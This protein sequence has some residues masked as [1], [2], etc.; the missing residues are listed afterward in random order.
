MGE[1][2]HVACAACRH[3]DGLRCGAWGT[4][5][6]NPE[7]TVCARFAGPDEEEGEAHVR[8][9]GLA[10]LSP[11]WLHRLEP[12]GQS[13]PWVQVAR[14]RR[15]R[16]TGTQALTRPLSSA[17]AASR[18]TNVL[19][20]GTG[21]LGDGA[22]DDA[23]QALSPLAWH[24]PPAAPLPDRFAGAL[25]G[26]ALGDAFG[27]PAEDRS[28]EEVLM[29][30]GGPLDMPVGRVGRRHAWPAGQVTRHTQLGLALA[31]SFLAAEGLNLDDFAA[32]LVR[33]LPRALRP[34]RATLQAV[35]AL[36]KGAHWSSSGVP[37]AGISGALRAM[38]LAL[39]CWEDPSALRQAA[40][41]QCWPTHTAPEA[42]AASAMLSAALAGALVA[43]A[44]N[45][46]PKPW[47]A[48]VMRA[49]QGMAPAAS[50]RLAL[51]SALLEVDQAP[52]E[53]MAQ[54]R[55]GG[56]ALECGGAGLFAFALHHDDPAAAIRL[57][58]NAGHDASATAAIAGALVGALRGEAG[59]PEG[60]VAA[61]PLSAAMR[62]MAARLASPAS[63]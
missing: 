43:E 62:D 26:L 56:F 37:S 19:G 46:H 57:A 45:F 30:Y 24:A 28:P 54:L 15:S 8:L 10:D 58:A 27:F 18:G 31:E 33:W 6:E 16:P 59:L 44:G 29:V 21:R 42:L 22:M 60:W 17:Q 34:G 13:S 61:M 50:E 35:E 14:R 40:V 3:L 1:G 11:D 4:A 5:I 52:E 47:L 7:Y 9:P 49:V 38:V 48:H 39:P 63:L 25:V 55:C 12:D 23:P 53:A 51:V 2:I 41:A 20:R 36:S 32:R